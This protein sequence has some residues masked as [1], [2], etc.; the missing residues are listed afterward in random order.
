MDSIVTLQKH[1][2][3]MSSKSENK[4]EAKYIYGVSTSHLGNLFLLESCGR[5]LVSEHTVTWHLHVS[6]TKSKTYRTKSLLVKAALEMKKT[7]HKRIKAL[8]DH[9]WAPGHP[10]SHLEVPCTLPS[11]LSVLQKLRWKQG[12]FCICRYHQK[13][14]NLPCGYPPQAQNS[15]RILRDSLSAWEGSQVNQSQTHFQESSLWGS[16]GSW[17]K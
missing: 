11:Q 15:M 3:H 5:S 7:Q 2:A 4:C 10:P 8:M 9:P 14:S 17:A 6:E 13:Q 16:S 1:P 12:C